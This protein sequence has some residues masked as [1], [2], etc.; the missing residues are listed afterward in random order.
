MSLVK[1][2]IIINRWVDKKIPE[3]DVGNKNRKDYKMNAI[4]NS[5]VFI[6]KLE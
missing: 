5:I 1:Q 3:L 6:E 4:W 2:D